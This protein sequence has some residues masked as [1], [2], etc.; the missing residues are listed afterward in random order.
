MKHPFLQNQISKLKFDAWVIKL[1]NPFSF[2]YMRL[3]ACFI[4]LILKSIQFYGAFVPFA[5]L[6]QESKIGVNL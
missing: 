6:L 3:P 4:M 1:K 2:Q 5:Q